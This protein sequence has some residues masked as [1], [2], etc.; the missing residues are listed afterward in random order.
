MGT[1]HV[2]PE[3]T[4]SIVESRYC[5]PVARRTLYVN[6]AGIKIK[7]N[8]KNNNRN[9]KSKSPDLAIPSCWEG[10]GCGLEFRLVSGGQG[11]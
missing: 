1:D 9:N 10:S 11:H 3:V 6:S 2:K 4:C 5:P 7:K 8:N